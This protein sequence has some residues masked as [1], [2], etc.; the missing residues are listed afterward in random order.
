LPVSY[1]QHGISSLILCLLQVLESLL[2]HGLFLGL[3]LR[4]LLRKH[5]FL[6]GHIESRL[7]LGLFLGLHLGF[8]LSD[9]SLPLSD[10]GL[11]DLG[12]SVAVLRQRLLGL[13]AF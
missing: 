1:V 2:Q 10:L 8:F 12:L 5:G 7:Q 11:S 4:L 6:L 13:N 9:L 3:R